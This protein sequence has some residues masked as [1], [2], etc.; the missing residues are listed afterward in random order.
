MPLNWNFPAKIGPK[1]GRQVNGERLDMLPPAP[2]LEQR[3]P[4]RKSP[5]S[6]ADRVPASS[7]FEGGSHRKQTIKQEREL[8]SVCCGGT[9][10]RASDMSA[11]NLAG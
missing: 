9:N 2:S 7:T 5:T 8:P 3:R 6:G 1:T 11:M 10:M 4:S